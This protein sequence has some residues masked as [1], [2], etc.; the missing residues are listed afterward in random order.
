M[1]T[2]SEAQFLKW[3]E[4]HGVLL[5]KRYPRSA[6][7]TFNRGPDLD[8]FWLIPPKPEARPHFLERLLHLMGKWQSCYAWRHM[9]RWPEKPG[10]RCAK[11]RVEFQILKGIGMPLGTDDVVEFKRSERDQ[12]TSLLFS[13]TVFG[14][15]VAEDLYL[16]PNHAQH[17]IE[18]SHHGVVYVYFREME[19]LEQFVKGM[20][21]EKFPLP[22]TVPDW[23][24]LT[25]AWMEKE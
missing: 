5:D 4:E 17:I 25:P 6:E 15:S 3:A 18:T 10:R 19:G 8:R 14:W 2:H 13:S 7:L 12:L 11:D 24:I 16:V 23:T 22:K 21:R 9:G 20:K 1:K